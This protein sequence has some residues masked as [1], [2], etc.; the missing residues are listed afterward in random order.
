MGQLIGNGIKERTVYCIIAEL[1]VLEHKLISDPSAEWTATRM[2]S[3]DIEC[4]AESC[5]VKSTCKRYGAEI[6]IAG[7]H[8]LV[9]KKPLDL[10]FLRMEE[11]SEGISVN[12]ISV[13]KD[14][15]KDMVEYRYVLEMPAQLEESELVAKF[16]CDCT[17]TLNE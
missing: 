7:Q 3:H 2:G 10:Y 16:D 14:V 8:Q 17:L 13:K 15:Q 9:H 5:E 12:D 6:T 1:R 4:A 11:S